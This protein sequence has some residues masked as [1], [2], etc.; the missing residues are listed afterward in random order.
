MTKPVDHGEALLTAGHLL[1]ESNGM[2][3]ADDACVVAEAYL[4]LHFEVEKLR[5]V[6]EAAAALIKC[7]PMLDVIGLGDM[8]RN[9]LVEALSAFEAQDE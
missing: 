9:K 7:G 1:T 4:A 8:P 6:R 2:V 5:R 3:D